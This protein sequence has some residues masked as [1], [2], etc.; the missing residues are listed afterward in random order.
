MK[1]WKSAI[2]LELLNTMCENTMVEHLGIVFTEIGE[3]SLTATMPVDKRTIQPLGI[4]HGGASAALAETLGS[5]AA[6]CCVD[7][8]RHFC[9]GLD[10]NTSHLKKAADGLVKGIAKPVHLGGMTHVWEIKIYD[11]SEDLISQ[12]R[13]T[14]V[15]LDHKKKS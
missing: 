1:L 2:T 7:H 5:I 10:I 4:M 6:N 11:E 9:V 14:V 8:E 15:V 13:L 12:S 3:D